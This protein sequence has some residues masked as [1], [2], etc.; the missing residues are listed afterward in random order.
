MCVWHGPEHGPV[1]V[2]VQI[3]HRLK[4]FQSTLMQKNKS[5]KLTSNVISLVIQSYIPLARGT[6]TWSRKLSSLGTAG[7]GP[8]VTF[9]ELKE[10]S[11][12]S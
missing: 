10:G 9:M 11:W 3:H 4:A 8:G 12:A 6:Q 1:S 7:L 2:L 5:R